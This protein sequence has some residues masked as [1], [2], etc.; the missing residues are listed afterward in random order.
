MKRSIISDQISSSPEE[1]FSIA[2]EYGYEYV[3]LHSVSGKTIE[4]LN[5]EDTAEVKRLLK[6][7]DLQVSNIASTIYFVCPLQESDAVSGFSDSF[8]VFEGDL[9][10]HLL[11]LKRACEIA[12]ELECGTVRL[13]PFRFPE[14][15]KPPFGDANDLERINEAM[16]QASEIAE[17]YGITLAVENCPYSHLPKGEMTLELIQAVN[18]P[19]VR[20]LY[21][22]ANSYRAVVNNVPERYR[23]WSL[24]TE[25]RKLA[26]YIAHVHVKNYHYDPN[27][28]PK[29]F[30]HVS[31][32]EGD[33]DY[34]SLLALLKDS[35]YE[36]FCSLE[37]EV[38]R[39]ETLASMKWMREIEGGL[40]E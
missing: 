30:V 24:E 18:R 33:I 13:F 38:N 39:E 9:K 4:T 21:D 2:R 36:G 10:A 32:G 16:I 27:V 23:S 19:N 22:P 3:E 6:R 25:V 15:R 20:L 37:P 12:C 26:P 31:A 17:P 28:Q 5:A 8:P 35:G 1:A 7:Y 29:P 40:F 34:R 11:Q 14:N